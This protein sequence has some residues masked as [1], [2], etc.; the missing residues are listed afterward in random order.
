MPNLNK[1]HLVPHGCLHHIN[2]TQDWFPATL[3]CALCQLEAVT[4][5]ERAF[6]LPL[7]C[8]P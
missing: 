1:C 7:L 5:V 6:I 2:R 3:K 4:E 8:C